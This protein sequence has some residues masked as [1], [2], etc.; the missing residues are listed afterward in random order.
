MCEKKIRALLQAWA[1]ADTG[2]SVSFLGL[3]DRGFQVSV[4][5]GVARPAASIMKLPLFMTAFDLA[6]YGHFPMEEKVAVQRLSSTRYASILTAL[7]ANHQLTYRELIKFGIIT[8]DN[9]ATLAVQNHVSFEAVSAF[10]QKLGC[11]G[12]AR[13]AAGFSEA[14]LGP[15]GREN[16]LTTDDALILLQKIRSEYP[17][18]LDAMTNNLRNTR[19]NLLLPEEWPA[20]HKTGSLDGVVNDI[21]LVSNGEKT[22]AIAFL[23]D[24]QKEPEQTSLAIAQATLAVAHAYFGMGS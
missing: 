5:G 11:S 8:S 13:M 15:K 4:R 23:S 3:G 21:G 20:P 17:V 18:I 10:M 14:E 1:G 9:P 12:Q 19:L 2:R 16:Q 6:V 22:F 7:D 24:G